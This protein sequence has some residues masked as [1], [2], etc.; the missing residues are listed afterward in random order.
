MNKYIDGNFGLKEKK[1]RQMAAINLM[2]NGADLN[3]ISKS[4]EEL[5]QIKKENNL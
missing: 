5:K 2:K 4:L 3:I 1:V